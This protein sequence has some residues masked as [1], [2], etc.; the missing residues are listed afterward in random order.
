MKIAKM[1]SPLDYNSGCDVVVSVFVS[2]LIVVN[3]LYSTFVK[4][5][6]VDHKAFG[7]ALADQ[8]RKLT[9]SGGR[10][11][12]MM[13]QLI[14]QVLYILIALKLTA[15][16]PMVSRSM[17]SITSILILTV[18]T[19]IVSV[20]LD[21]ILGFI[22]EG[23]DKENAAGDFRKFTPSLTQAPMV[24]VWQ[25]ILSSLV[26][27]VTYLLLSYKLCN[28]FSFLFLFFIL[29]FGSLVFFKT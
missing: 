7:N 12:G 21:T 2:I 22:L 9:E 1:L 26:A 6:L 29:L 8:L 18:F 20:S 10:Y 16:V 13:L 25:L 27:F 5:A 15:F 3:I 28:N 23:L 19:T 4:Y 14:K 24:L 17:N 11:E